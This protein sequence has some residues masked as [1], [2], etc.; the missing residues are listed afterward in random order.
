ME[1]HPITNSLVIGTAPDGSPLR[2]WSEGD[3]T[4]IEAYIYFDAISGTTYGTVVV[5]ETTLETA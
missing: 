5:I 1:H 2:T 4:F 3:R